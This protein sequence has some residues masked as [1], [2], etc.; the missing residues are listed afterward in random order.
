LRHFWE[1]PSGKCRSRS[2][3][4]SPSCFAAVYLDNSNKHTNY[5]HSA[6]DAVT[7]RFSIR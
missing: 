4:F 2:P 3:W 5:S 6:A 7:V 1:Q